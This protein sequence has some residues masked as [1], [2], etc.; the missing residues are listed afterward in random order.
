MRVWAFQWVSCKMKISHT[1]PLFHSLEI[2]PV[3]EYVMFWIVIILMRVFALST[4]SI[5][6]SDGGLWD[7]TFIQCYPMGVCGPEH[8][9][10]ILGLLTWSVELLLQSIIS[11]NGEPFIFKQGQIN[12]LCLQKSGGGG[13]L[14]CP[15]KWRSNN[16]M[17]GTTNSHYCNIY[18]LFQQKDWGSRALLVIAF[19]GE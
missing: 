14:Y 19:A 8:T 7:K 15:I 9:A 2:N 17:R 1:S 13:H 12:R 16:C 6:I 10:C 5:V 4:V 11:T 18:F 3:R